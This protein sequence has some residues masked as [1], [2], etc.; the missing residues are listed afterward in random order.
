MKNYLPIVVVAGA[1]SLSGSVN[2]GSV[3]V[4]RNVSYYDGPDGDPTRQK[5]DI[6]LP[7]GVSK[8][9]T[10]V[11]FHGGTWVM[12]SKDGFL[13]LPGHR[14]ADH[15]KFFAEHGIAAVFANYRLSPKVKHPEHVTDAAR[16]F[17]WVRRNMPKYGG[18]PDQLFVMGHSAGG[19]L[20][21]LL[22]SDPE[23]LMTEGLTPNMIR[24]VIC[25]S[26]VFVLSG[27]I[28]SAGGEHPIKGPGMFFTH[29]FGT[30]PLVH[31]QASPIAHVHPGMPPF[32][33]AY[34]D[35]DII[36]LAAQAVTFADAVKAARN[37]V[38]TLLM[39]GRSHQSILKQS[40]QPDDQLGTAILNFIRTGTP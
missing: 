36:T 30:D 27:E 29:V 21:S 2:A 23:Y 22:A 13:A 18:D 40:I 16:A 6:Y 25:V 26:G 11:F 9:P 15:G 4:I 37:P 7:K 5:L 12:G 33:I 39:T 19:H 28:E 20:A 24:G 14:A 34:A 1:L 32:L 17:A 3:E 35:N 31:R 38:H 8:F 10:V